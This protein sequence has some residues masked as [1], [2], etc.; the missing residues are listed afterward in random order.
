MSELR[1]RQPAVKSESNTPETSPQPKSHEA[2]DTGISVT[3]IIRLIVTFV[4]ATAGLSYYIT[5]G[6]SFLYGYRPWYTRWPNNILTQLK[7]QNGPVNLT[8]AELALFNG[9][10]ESLP[11]YLAV[12]G[13]I[14]DVS[15]NPRIY[16]PGG[17][18][19][20]FSGRDATR[21]FV[22]GCF[23]EDLTPDMTGVEEM[24]MPIEDV[25]NESLSSGEK[26]IRRQQ[27]LKKARSHVWASV[28]GWE[29]FFRNHK[30]YFQAGKVVGAD[31]TRDPEFGKRK[32]CE[33]A[34]Q[35]RPKRSE[36]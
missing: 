30:R 18:Y 15:A 23:D 33:A 28:D 29:R 34:L 4:I 17:G 24:F 21:A 22:T 9:V 16:G 11:I 1:Q 36:M 12:N 2:E 32:L 5:Q 7:F 8:P 13:S 27:E 14:F 3:D 35:K 20:F 26:K 10:D 6:E 19:N 25:P 31:V